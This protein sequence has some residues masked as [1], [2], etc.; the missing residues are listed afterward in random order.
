MNDAREEAM[1]KVDFDCEKHAVIIELAG[2]VDAAQAEQTLAELDSALAKAEKGFK[3]LID[4][5]AVE[6][7]EPEVEAEIMKG[8]D[9]FNAK[10]VSE[11]VR[12]FPDPDLEIGFNMLSLFH[13]SPQVLVRSART[14]E[15]AEA[16]L[17]E[18]IKG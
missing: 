13:Y 16:L 11:V 3:L 2:N 6:T 14:R 15:E 7:M 5:S 9:F 10:G 4:Y 12:V 18:K 8:M 1:I 17:R